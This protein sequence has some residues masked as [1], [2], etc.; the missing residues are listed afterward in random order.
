MTNSRTLERKVDEAIL[1]VEL[2]KKRT[3]D[4]ILFDYL[5][6]SYFGS[7]AYGIGAASEIYFD[8]PISAVN[9]SE[10]ATLAG[11]VKAPSYYSPSTNSERAEERRKLVLE[12]MH[13]EG[14]IS[15]AE[16]SESTKLEL[17]PL[18]NGITTDPATLIHGRKDKGA[19]EYP[20]ISD[21]VESE[22]IEEFGE[23][24]VYRGGLTI[25]TTIDPSIQAKA[26]QAVNERLE[27]TEHPVDMSLVSVEPSTGHVK[28]LVG[29]RDYATSQVNLALGGSTGFQPGSSFKPLVLATAFEK[30]L[31][32]DTVYPAPASWN[33]PGCYG[34]E[35]DISNYSNLSLIHI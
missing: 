17:W 4:E 5:N 13:A 10:A 22:L 6:I 30:G 25:E 11:L 35:C 3:K 2:E 23:D 14:Y 12:L 31:G 9:I 15:S 26:V 21:W 34:D 24:V 18:S 1:A 33:A 8:K 20:Y 29:G 27:N 28:A 7:G 32:P 16:L 19:S